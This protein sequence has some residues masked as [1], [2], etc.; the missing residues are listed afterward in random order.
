MPIRDDGPVARTPRLALRALGR[1]DAEHIVLL[2]SD[3]QVLT[4]VHDVPF[5]STEAAQRWIEDI[6]VQLPH[7]IG[8]WAI[9]AHEGTWIGR[10][11][12]RRNAEGETS[13]GY[14]LLRAHWG[15]GYATEAVQAMLDLAFTRHHL[16][17]VVSKIHRDN[18][19]SRR[20]IE[21]NGGRF[22]KE[23]AAENFAE[24]LVFR[25]DP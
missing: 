1:Q 23:G 11:S 21:K 25:F 8:R 2:N 10:C 14:R 12:L 9:R 3:P 5:P 24:A 7:G 22:W 19:A 20:V 15:Q 6:P 18:A 17:Y 16:P 13:M 4:Y